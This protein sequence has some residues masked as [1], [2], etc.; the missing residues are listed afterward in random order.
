LTDL[1]G[2][3][4]CKK[5][6]ATGLSNDVQKPWNTLRNRIRNLP[7]YHTDLLWREKNKSIFSFD[8]KGRWMAAAEIFEHDGNSRNLPAWRWM[9]SLI[10]DALLLLKLNKK[11]K[12]LFLGR[13]EG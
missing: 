4:K 3:E 8:S 10:L 5:K 11:Q 7:G 2:R 12:R 6:K 9:I 13:V 1:L